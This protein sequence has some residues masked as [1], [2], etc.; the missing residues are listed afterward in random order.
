MKE[1]KLFKPTPKMKRAEE[2]LSRVVYAAKKT[3]TKKNI[4]ATAV[5]PLPEGGLPF[6]I[7]YT[8]EKLIKGDSLM[9]DL[10]AWRNCVERG[11]VKGA[12]SVTFREP[13]GEWIKISA[14]MEGENMTFREVMK[15]AKWL[16][17]EDFGMMRTDEEQAG[18]AEL[19]AEKEA[20]K[21]KL[22]LA[23]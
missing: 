13:D 1:L 14:V 10:Y 16:H 11:E 22:K 12:D 5:T 19:A 21:P 23:E 3:V 6:M 4:N 9:E 18:L 20:A 2:K 8:V 17:A 15:Y 7:Q